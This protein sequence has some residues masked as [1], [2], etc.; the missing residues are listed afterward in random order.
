MNLRL[1]I[2]NYRRPNGRLFIL[3]SSYLRVFD[4]QQQNMYNVKVKFIFLRE[5]LMT[6]ASAVK[7]TRTHFYSEAANGVITI[8]L[9]RESIAE[10]PNRIVENN[11]HTAVLEMIAYFFCAA[12]P[13]AQLP[14][15]L[16]TAKSLCE[17]LSH[18][19]LAA[20]HNM[21]YYAQ[22]LVQVYQWTLH[23][24]EPFALTP[25]EQLD[26]RRFCEIVI[27]TEQSL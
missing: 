2:L 7:K 19:E 1:I 22:L 25:V 18:K 8:L 26:L 15:D 21:E 12:T 23:P 13:M 4:K 9:S 6:T 5:E 17:V 24:A 3:F 14:A 20:P 16:C 11:L 27:S 10:E